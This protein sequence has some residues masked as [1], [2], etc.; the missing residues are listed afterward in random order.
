MA[1][2]ELGWDNLANGKLLA[3]AQRQFDVLIT[4]DSNIK[5]QQRLDAFDLALI[6]LRAFDTKLESYLPLMPEIESVL[7]TIQMHEVV[8]I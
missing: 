2:H 5:Y 4:T 6:V 3:K 8:Y 1:V 7:T